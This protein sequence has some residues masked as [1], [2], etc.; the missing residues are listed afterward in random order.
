MKRAILHGPRDLRIEEFRLDIEHL[1]AEQIW[2]QTQITAL[3]IGT[4]RGNYE[5][6]ERVPGAPYYPRWVGDSNLGV[7]RR[8]GKK[9]TRFKPGERVFS[10]GPHESDYIA[11]QSDPVIKVPD[12][13]ASEDAVYL[14]LY[15]VSALSF[16]VASYSPCENVAIVGL[17]VL[18]LAA[19]ALGHAFGARVI[20]L[21]N[22]SLRLEMAVKM[23]A[24]LALMS[25]DP[26]LLDKIRS[27]TGEVGVD[28]VILT[29]NPWPACRVASEVARSNGRISFLALPGRGESP[30]DYNPLA[31]R[32]FQAKALA[33]KSVGHIPPYLYPILGNRFDLKNTGPAILQ[34]MAEGLVEPKRLITHRFSYSEMVQAY[35]MA[36]SREKSMLG[37]LFEW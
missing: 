13:V 8:V 7:V 5:G 32:W 9:V 20:A 15:H 10:R 36:L 12:G 14:G 24:A 2:V 18:G 25:D 33:L 4:D 1:E 22:S 3:K 31:M 26:D 19:V 6:A 37:V 29:A 16:W 34:L 35:E 30:L 27:F 21:G 17:G 11:Q 23:G 28:L